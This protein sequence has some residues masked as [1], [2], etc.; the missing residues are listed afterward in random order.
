MGMTRAEV[1]EYLEEHDSPSMTA[2]ALDFGYDPAQLGELCKS[3][4]A[5]RYGMWR[6]IALAE[7]RLYT[8]VYGPLAVIKRVE[9]LM[10][11]G[12]GEDRGSAGPNSLSDWVMQGEHGESA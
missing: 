9:Q 5:L 8:H 2:L 6:I 12:M 10:G 3:D 4:E 1:D 7:G 11:S